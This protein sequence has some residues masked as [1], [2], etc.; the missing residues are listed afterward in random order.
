M[1]ALVLGKI[2]DSPGGYCVAGI[3]AVAFLVAWFLGKEENEEEFVGNTLFGGDVSESTSAAEAQA[4]SFDAQEYIA[5]KTSVDGRFPLLSHGAKEA[6]AL[7]SVMGNLS[8]QRITDHLRKYEFQNAERVFDDLHNDPVTFIVSSGLSEFKLNPTLEKVIKE[9]LRA[10]EAEFLKIISNM[11]SEPYKKR[12]T[13]EPGFA[14]RYNA[15][16]SRL[17]SSKSNEI[18][19]ESISVR[20]KELYRT[21]KDRYNKSTFDLFLLVRLELRDKLESSPFSYRFELFMN[22]LVER[23]EQKH[24]LSEWEMTVWTDGD[25]ALLKH[26]LVARPAA[27]RMGDP[28]EGWLHFVTNPTT[29][30]MLEKC[31]IRLVVQSP[32]NSN[33]AEHEADP[34]IWNPRKGASI[35]RAWK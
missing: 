35:A 30:E 6:L 15:L 26:P 22:G 27:L 8:A 33:Y 14:A 3:L 19:P 1:A 20:L 23:L 24:D 7:F 25:P 16:S 12:L 5:Q 11:P 9:A 18:S 31:A 17:P 4:T 28:V 13:S 10:D 2:L 29:G 34:L 32:Y 21:P